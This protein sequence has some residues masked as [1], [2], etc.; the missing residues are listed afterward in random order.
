VSWRVQITAGGVRIDRRGVFASVLSTLKASNTF[1]WAAFL[2]ALRLPFIATHHVQ[3]DAL[4]GLRCARDL[5]LGLGY[6]FNAG[7]RVSASTAHGYVLLGALAYRVF[8]EAF[9]PVLQLIFTGCVIAGIYC[10]ASALSSTESE[11]TLLWVLGSALPIALAI[12]YLALETPLL[13]LAVGLLILDLKHPLP[14]WMTCGL[15]AGLPWIRADAAAI[16]LLILA[17]Q[18]LRDRRVNAAVA[19][20]LASG[21]ITVLIFNRVYFGQWLNQSIAAKAV[22]YHSHHS[23]AAFARNLSYIYLGL[24]GTKSA[25]ISLFCPLSTRYLLPLWAVWSVLGLLVC[26]WAI[27]I[28]QRE[29]RLR[30]PLA[31]LLALGLLLPLPYAWGNVLFSWYFHPSMLCLHLLALLWVV[32]AVRS[33]PPHLRAGILAGTAALVACLAL[34]QGALAVN[35]GAQ[36]YYYRG[37][38]GRYLRSISAPHDTLLLEPAGYIPYY[39]GLY[40]WDEIGIVSPEVIRFK[41][42]FG[43]DWWVA[44]LKAHHP[45]F[46]VL[47]DHIFSSKTTEGDLIRPEDR[48]WFDSNYRLIYGTAYRSEVVYRNPLLVRIAQAGSACDYFIFRFTPASGST[49]R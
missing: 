14:R 30:A 39:S 28:A 23:L 15:M 12:S 9:I 38:I 22:L 42:R 33:I 34:G 10:V 45:T 19:S 47:R 5:G 17:C 32:R 18:V 44:F 35:M 49:P 7:E 26:L 8:G 43:A 11:R 46:L 36:E 40:T 2:V 25:L 6:G 24:G 1:L 16:G 48:A 27:N 13:V 3:E 37:G 21:P 41:Q 20:A 31:A 29:A 4:I